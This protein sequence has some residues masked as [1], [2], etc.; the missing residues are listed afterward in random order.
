MPAWRRLVA[1]LSVIL[2]GLVAAP[3]T[4]SAHID[5]RAEAD[6]LHRINAERAR[7]SLPLLRV[8]T[9][10]RDVARRHSVRMAERKRIHH[11]PRLGAEV[12]CWR[13]LG[14]N[15]GY[16][17]TTRYLHRVFMTS[18]PH[19]ANILSRHVT[20]VGVG[21]ERRGDIIWVTQLFRLPGR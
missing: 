19:R 8:R 10:L 20:E 4:A 15:I 18:T 6:L 17:K 13:E 2:I 14:E 12:C 3:G 5:V 11:N 9:D 21:V 16:A 7:R 1:A